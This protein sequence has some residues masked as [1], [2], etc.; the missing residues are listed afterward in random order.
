[1]TAKI[2]LKSIYIRPDA[3]RPEVVSMPENQD[4]VKH[5]TDK[6]VRTDDAHKHAGNAFSLKQGRLLLRLRA[7]WKTANLFFS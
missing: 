5:T 4:Y 1:M 6:E 7:E 2:G 3:G